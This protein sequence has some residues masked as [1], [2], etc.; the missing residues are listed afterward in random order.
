MTNLAK[1]DKLFHIGIDVAKAK[2]DIHCLETNEN[3]QIENSKKGLMKFAGKHHKML[4]ESYVTIDTTG[5]HE[6]LCCELLHEKGYTVHQAHSYR[7]KNFIRSM[8]CEAKTDRLDAIMLAS[9]GKERKEKLRV[10]APASKNQQVLKSLVMRREELVKM[11][12]QEKNRQAGPMASEMKKSFEA[13]LKTLEKEIG[14]IEKRIKS[15]IKKDEMMRA[16]EQIL[17]AIKG[18]GEKTS[19]SLLALLPELGEL[20]RK[21]VAALAGLAPYANDSGNYNGYR[22]VRGGRPALRRALFMAALSAVRY[23]DD[24]K[25]FY[26][27][28][29]NHGKKAIV[30]LTATAR[31]LATIANARIR[32]MDVN[33]N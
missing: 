11:Q 33:S 18:I 32:D 23:N 25:E 13:V 27:R 28:L 9:Y 19:F 1:Q 30:A 5:G 17:L 20:D 22:S 4:L 10:Y 6:H 24:L 2:L 29:R 26:Q 21:Q 8:G 14:K 3:W 31:K 12:T 15:C 7:V 16:K